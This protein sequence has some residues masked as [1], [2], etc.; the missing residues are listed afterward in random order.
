MAYSVRKLTTQSFFS[1]VDIMQA[2][3]LDLVKNWNL[4][5]FCS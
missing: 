3:K 1:S 2:K 4:A 5:F